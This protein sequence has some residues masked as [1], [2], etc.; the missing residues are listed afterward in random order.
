ME[1]GE[2]G[3]MS[4]ESC[5]NSVYCYWIENGTCRDKH[6]S[7]ILASSH[8][9]CKFYNAK[10]TYGGNGKCTDMGVCS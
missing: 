3:L 8:T 5:D 1:K 2:C 10:C 7:D 9:V 6:C 4:K